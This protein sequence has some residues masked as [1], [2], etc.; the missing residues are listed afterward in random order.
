MNTET[1]LQTV[2]K[3]V[4]RGDELEVTAE[5]PQEMQQANSAIIL[6]CDRKMQRLSADSKELKESYEHAVKRKWKSSTLKRHYDLTV[7]RIEFY[8]KIKSALEHGFYIVPAFP[9]T[10][11]A[12]RTE[13]KTP[14]KLISTNYWATHEQPT[15][16][17]E[18]GVGE[19]KNPFP[20]VY[21]IDVTSQKDREQNKK[22]IQ[23]LAK[24]YDELE[25]PVNMSK[26]Y[27]M[28]ATNRAMTLK[29]FDDFGILPNTKPK[30]D[31]IIVARLRDPRGKK[32][33]RKFVHFIIAWH[34]DTES[35]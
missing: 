24:E 27:I 3:I 14:L 25:F 15:E 20:S 16:A 28:E 9:V 22:T 1:A 5:T 2:Q 13:R 10:V 31:P 26:P 17:L 8:S 33:S 11:F 4:H 30:I 32:R 35:L 21:Q 29:I 6:W 7:K 12:L 19:Y 34:L 18:Q 23:Y